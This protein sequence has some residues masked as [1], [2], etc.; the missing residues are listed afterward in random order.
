MKTDTQI[1]NEIAIK[2]GYLKELPKEQSDAQKLLLLDMYNDISKLCDKHNLVYM[3]GGGTCLG[4][5][6]HKG[7]IPWDDDLDIMLPRDSYEKLIVL[8]KKGLLGE[9]YEFDTPNKNSDCKNTFLKIFRKGTLDVEITSENAPGPRGIFID[10]FPMDYAPKTYICRKLKG[11]CSDLLQAICSCVLY[12]EYPSTLYKEFMH[13]TAEGKKRYRQRMFLGKIFGIIPHRKWVWWFDQFNASS[14]DTGYLTIPTGRKHYM[15]ECRPTEVY[16]PV[17]TAK[18]EGLNVNV[19][20]KVVDYLTSMYKNYM[21][22][23]PMEKRER[24]FVYK[25]KLPQE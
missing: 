23:P 5:V 21:E 3:L 7:Y 12:V 15:G 22:I 19:P 11:L 20:H 2:T 14:K 24:H 1:M 13:Q 25:F 8:L 17:A 16:L 10:V 9:K 6:R 4:A 18:F